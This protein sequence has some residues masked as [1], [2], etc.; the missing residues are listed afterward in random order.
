MKT[1]AFS[2]LT[3]FISTSCFLVY[4][5][6]PTE[7]YSTKIRKD[8]KEIGNLHALESTEYDSFDY[9]KDSVTYTLDSVKS[10]AVFFNVYMPTISVK[11]SDTLSVLATWTAKDGATNYISPYHLIYNADLSISKNELKT[12]LY[13][14]TFEVEVSKFSFTKS[15]EK[16]DADSFYVPTGTIDNTYVSF[17]AKCDDELECPFTEELI[18]EIVNAFLEKNKSLMN[19]NFQNNGVVA[20]YKSLPFN[21]LVQK[22]YTQT[23][24]TVS[25][26][27]NI[28]LSLEELPVLSNNDIIFKRKGKLND[29][30]IEGDEILEDTTTNQKFYI[31]KKVLQNL[32][33]NNLFNINYEQSA[34]PSLEF[35]LTIAYLKQII[36]VSAAYEDTE[37]LKINAEMTN[38]NFNDGEELSGVLTLSVNVNTRTDLKTVF[39]FD[40]DFGF[41]LTPTLLQNGL[42][43]VLLS[44]NLSINDVKTEYTLNDEDLFKEWVK[45]SYLAGLGRSEYNLLTLA[46][47]LSYYFTTNKLSYE[48]KDNYLCIVR[49]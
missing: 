34:N 30:E 42:N 13:E 27:N 41:K 14:I 22:L 35:E 19:Q 47:D 21:E 26:E 24:T 46:F 7:L 4:E 33:K 31:N 3:L 43:F 11:Q 2:L 1:I 29:L 32:I 8:L 18:L 48:F 6:V 49:A 37:E 28:D 25:Y 36:T 10:K 23:Y 12:T 17:K 16:Y 44:K 9:V 20:Y 39:S 45:N 5:K 40:C 15:W 38:V